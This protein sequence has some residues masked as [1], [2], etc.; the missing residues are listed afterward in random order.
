M[1]KRLKVL[2]TT[3]IPVPYRIDFFNELG[4]L[5]DLTV[6]F[7]RSSAKTRDSQWLNSKFVNFKGLF[8]KGISI[9]DDLAICPGIINVV[10]KSKFDRIIVG[11]YYSFTGILLTQ[12]LRMMHIPF[13]M[14]G[15]GGQIQ[16]ESKLKFW[17]KRYLNSGAY[18][19]LTTSD[20]SKKVLMRYGI[21]ENI[22]FKYPFT[23][24]NKEDIA[25]KS[26]PDTEKNKFVRV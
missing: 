10:R 24:L 14:T 13:I 11:I 12:Y 7:E 26:I 1:N 6:V 25:E 15:D 2:F 17:I 16:H 8:L 18:K 19:Y 22:I 5:V 23:S 9:G 3:N 21:K 4:K 20:V